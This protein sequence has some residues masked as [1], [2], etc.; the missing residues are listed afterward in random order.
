VKIS[1]LGGRKKKQKL[2]TCDIT[3]TESSSSSEDDEED[4]SESEQES[5][6]ESEEVPTMEKPVE[7]EAP[8]TSKQACKVMHNKSTEP[9]HKERKPVEHIHI[10]RKPEIQVF[11]N[12]CMTNFQRSILHFMSRSR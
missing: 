8:S 1:A 4:Y 9:E 2:E 10:N 12:N 3:D 5:E 6:Q 7:P 11:L